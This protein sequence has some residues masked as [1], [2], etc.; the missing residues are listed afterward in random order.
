MQRLGQ[1]TPIV[2]AAL[3]QLLGLLC[4]GES[5][6]TAA[7]G[8]I[9]A[10]LAPAAAARAGG[11]LAAVAADEARHER[12]LSAVSARTCIA[13]IL[14][15]RTA[16][17]F[18]ARLESRD[19]QIHAARVASLD[20]CVCQI[21]GVVLGASNAG[22]IPTPVASLLAMI[23]RDEARH[24]R[25]MRTVARDLA[26]DA[27]ALRSIDLETRARFLAVLAVYEPHFASLGVEWGTVSARIRR[28]DA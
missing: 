7:I 27:S 2:N 18:F 23:R 12:L 11:T 3:A 5:S 25:A 26:V 15:G 20:G 17:R 16:R 8:R 4:A 9:G 22:L 6:A 13:P 14:P 19:P 1:P 28:D 10:R 24:V 21:L